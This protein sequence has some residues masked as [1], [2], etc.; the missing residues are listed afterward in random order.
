MSLRQFDRRVRRL[1]CAVMSSA[2][3]HPLLILVES[4]VP[5]RELAVNEHL[6]IDRFRDTGNIAW[7]Q[8]RITADP[9]DVGRAC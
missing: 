3:H 2:I 4:P 1:E 9:G 8:E 7:A 6:V 5:L